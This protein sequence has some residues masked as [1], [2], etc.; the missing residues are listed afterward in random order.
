[1]I[2]RFGDDIQAGIVTC[3][4]ESM[5]PIFNNRLWALTVAP[6]WQIEDCEHCVEITEPEGTG[7]VHI[8]SARKT[9]GVISSAETFEQIKSECPDEA[10]I[11]EVTCGD[12][13]G[14]VSEYADWS[15]SK[16]WRKWFVTCRQDLLF[17]SHN[18]RMGEEEFE[19]DLVSTLLDSLRSRG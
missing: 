8:S 15:S 14:Y 2:V 11:E 17:I 5:N 6:P 3:S 13:R 19:I 10:D 1:L 9:D 7:A 4:T 16:Y 18:C 12:C